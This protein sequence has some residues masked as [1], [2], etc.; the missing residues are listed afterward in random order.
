MEITTVK[1]EKFDVKANDWVQLKWHGDKNVPYTLNHEW[2]KV[3]SFTARGNLVVEAMGELSYPRTIVAKRH[4][5]NVDN[6]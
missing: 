1:G 5:L 3:K 6:K 4:V 2:A